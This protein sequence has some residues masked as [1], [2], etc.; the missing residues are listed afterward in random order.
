MIAKELKQI[1]ADNHVDLTGCLEK[2][3]IIKKMLHK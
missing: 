1:A 3:E 2:E